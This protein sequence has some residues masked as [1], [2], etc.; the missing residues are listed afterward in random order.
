MESDFA[1]IS[2]F[3]RCFE[4]KI[5]L[6]DHTDFINWKASGKTRITLGVDDELRSY[7]LTEIYTT[8]SFE[9][10]WEGK[11]SNERNIQRRDCCIHYL[12][13]G[14]KRIDALNC[15]RNNPTQCTTTNV[16]RFNPHKTSNT[17]MK[18]KVEI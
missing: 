1:Q 9:K 6:E 5:L 16:I 7:Y 8:V 10:E 2:T 18:T 13:I 14:H 4:T 3:L 12:L 11:R 17:C 15:S